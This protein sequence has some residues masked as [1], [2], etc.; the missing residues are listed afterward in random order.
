MS[1]YRFNCVCLAGLCGRTQVLAKPVGKAAC[2]PLATDAYICGSEPATGPCVL[3]T[4][5][6]VDTSRLAGDVLGDG[7]CGPSYRAG[8]GRGIITV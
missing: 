3:P 2:L 8:V 4:E 6:Q 5:E 7:G 1:A